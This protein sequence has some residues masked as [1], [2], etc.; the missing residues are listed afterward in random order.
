MT[1]FTL[2]SG[3]ICRPMRSPWG[4]FPTRSMGVASTLA[5]AIRIGQPVSLLADT[6][7]NAGNVLGAT[8][9][10][11]INLVGIAAEGISSGASS[12][13]GGNTISVWEAN[14]SVEFKAVTK[15]GLIGSSLVGK[16]RSM[17]WD[18]TLNIAWIDTT[19]S[20]ATDWRV[21]VTGI[22][23]GDQDSGGY[24]A[25]RFLAETGSQI[26]STILSSSP[27]LAFYS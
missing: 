1:D 11:V 10:N 25:F 15:G 8:M 20:T 23:D 17:N 16:R 2:S 13:V 3:S 21:V 19:A 18:S 24:V 14:P 26:N 27:L 22:V 12:L 4:A 9:P 5:A 6:S 7:T